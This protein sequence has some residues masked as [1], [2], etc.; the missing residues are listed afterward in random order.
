MCEGR[1][2][3]ITKQTTDFLL[4][5]RA[6]PPLLAFGCIRACL[7]S[8]SVFLLLISWQSL[9]RSWVRKLRASFETPEAVQQSSI[10]L[11]NMEPQNI[12][13]I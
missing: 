8:S 9:L 6:L 13:G 12:R 11:H 10:L 4:D 3:V 2:R 1:R 7:L 5:G